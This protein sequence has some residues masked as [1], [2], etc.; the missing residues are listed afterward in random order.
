MKLG[1]V[2]RRPPTPQRGGRHAQPEWR[3]HAFEKSLRALS[4]AGL[5]VAGLDGLAAWPIA[6]A[7]PLRL[8]RD[9]W[10][11]CA[12]SAL[13]RSLVGRSVDRYIQPTNQSP[14]SSL[15]ASCPSVC[16]SLSVSV[17]C[18]LC[19]SVCLSVCL[20]ICQSVSVCLS[21]CPSVRPSVCLSVRLSVCLSVCRPVSA[22]GG[23]HPEF[24]PRQARSKS[25]E[26]RL[27]GWLARRL[28]GCW[29][30]P[31]ANRPREKQA[32]GNSSGNSIRNSP[33]KNGRALLVSRGRSGGKARRAARG[34]GRCAPATG[35]ERERERERES[36]SPA[37][38]LREGSRE[39]TR[40]LPRWRPAPSQ[41]RAGR[42]EPAARRGPR[43]GPEHHG[44]RPRPSGALPRRPAAA[45]D[46]PSPPASSAGRAEGARAPATLPRVPATRLL[47]GGWAARRRA[48]RSGRSYRSRHVT[49]GD[50]RRARSPAP[51]PTRVARR[52]PAGRTRSRRSSI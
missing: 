21:V 35:R 24:D 52:T 47:R 1:V 41:R 27:A 51:P 44:Q 33:Q 42:R 2:G 49:K 4:T 23:V 6:A 3:D 15:S 30:E 8:A 31:T 43:R 28:M 36:G 11:V 13:A 45:R 37:S 9:I 10:D 48:A 20:S 40:R 26:S 50:R 34:P 5:A 25:S 17:L 7:P 38:R 46:E 14:L 12:A 39:G 29:L 18:L 32:Q 19:P 22:A 16:L